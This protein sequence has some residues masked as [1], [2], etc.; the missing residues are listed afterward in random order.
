MVLKSRAS[1]RSGDPVLRLPT[2]GIGDMMV[3][4][5]SRRS[6]VVSVGEAFGWVI[7]VVVVL[8]LLVSFWL[9]GRARITENRLERTSLEAGQREQRRG[10]QDFIA[11]SRQSRAVSRP[12][13]NAP[14]GGASGQ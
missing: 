6:E 3:H 2:A 13:A 7:L 14:A 12:A 9:C 5:H 1:G 11:L 8:I 10:I 4:V